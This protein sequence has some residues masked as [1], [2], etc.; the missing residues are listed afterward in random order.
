[1]ID[2]LLFSKNLDSILDSIHN[3]TCERCAH[4]VSNQ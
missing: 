3:T 2:K 4:F 1:M